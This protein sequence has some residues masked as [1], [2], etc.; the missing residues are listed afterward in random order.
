MTRDSRV[1]R[2][3]TVAAAFGAATATGALGLAAPAANAASGAPH[4]GQISYSQGQAWYA[5][6]P[7][8]SGKHIV[9]PSGGGFDPSDATPSPVFSPDGTRAV[10]MDETTGSLWTS[11]ADGTGARL[12]DKAT[13]PIVDGVDPADLAPQ[14]LDD[15]TIVFER[16]NGGGYFQIKADGSGLTAYKAPG[17]LQGQ[18]VFGPGGL[19]AGI[20][21]NGYTFTISIF[22]PATSTVATVPNAD[23]ISFSPD[24]K[25]IA[26]TVYGGGHGTAQIVVANID[27]TSPTTLT[28]VAGS[29]FGPVWSPDGTEIAFQEQTWTAA[30]GWGTNNLDVVPAAGGDPKAIITD[31]T[32]A[33]GYLAWDNGPLYTG[34]TN[35]P[36]PFLPPVTRPA[37]DRLGGAD[38]VDTAV[39][40]SGYNTADRG[41]TVSSHGANVVAKTA[42]LSRDDQFADAL[43]GNALAIAKGGPLLL[44]DRHKLS[45][46]VAKELTR[47]LPPG[48]TIY[49]LGGEQAL[50][51]QVAADVTALGFKV[52]RIGGTDRFATSVHIAQTIGG[53]PGSVAVATGKDYPDALTAGAGVSGSS[54]SP[55]VTTG[56]VLLT[57][58]G[59]LP[60]ETK[61]YL[62]GIDPTVSKVYAVGGPG[63]TAV[64]T[65]EPSWHG[66]VTNLSGSDRYATA[67]AVANSAMFQTQNGGP[68]VPG[69]ATGRNWPD[70]LS[71][72]ALTGRWGSPLLLADGGTLPASELGWLKQHAPLTKTGLSGLVGALPVFGGPVAVP[73]SVVKQVGVALYG[74]GKYD[75]FDNRHLATILGPF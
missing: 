74:A 17:G 33:G 55:K 26:H 18:L 22:D 15:S 66:K 25:K 72:G 23:S 36:S 62:A 37:I 56:V 44:T 8:G 20:Q 24:G 54:T 71:G 11:N 52:D 35:A 47:I 3:L 1:A 31:A 28:H 10:F 29:A 68:V 39:K 30:S 34:P 65:G 73:D 50:S 63:V 64:A 21:N 5:V 75:V 2:A 46:E 42:V 41:T 14:W 9:T 6:N 27:G 7:D 48:A 38:R 53:T 16:N 58:G 13:G 51:P 69:I 19:V 67:A 4:N 40:V 61:D 32:I 57:D 60:K 70:A 43:S 59:A 49:L 45:P 12:L